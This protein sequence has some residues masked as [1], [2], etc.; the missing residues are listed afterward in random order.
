MPTVSFRKALIFLVCSAASCIAARAQDYPVRPVRLVT[1]FAPGGNA[2]ILARVIA[3]GLTKNLGQSF[4]VDNRPGGSNIIGTQFVAKSA[5]DGYTLLLISTSHAVNPGLFGKE[6]PYDTNR[7]FD[8]ITKVGS[9]PM[10]LV[11]H[12]GAGVNS[13]KE[14]IEKARAS[15]GS[16]N[17]ASS[18]NGSPAHMAGALFNTMGQVR[19]THV[20]Y[21]GTQQGVT[22]ALAGQVQLAFPSLSSAGD[23]IKSGKLKALGITSAKRSPVAPGIPAIAETL[24]G[25]QADI[26]N[27]VVAPAGVP[28]PIVKKLNIEISKVLTAP[29]VKAKLAQMGV[30]V[31][32]STAEEFDVFLDAEIKKWAKVLGNSQI[33]AEVKR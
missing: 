14:L 24:P 31:D 28:R 2:D 8:G 33:N 1:S 11:A 27:G 16:F 30:D 23:L 22:D 4:F 10:V 20:P 29:E 15:P 25:F 17:F 19:T 6:L 12:P 3:D 21:K 18:G 7:D 26:W 5:P 32:V 9:T 13:L